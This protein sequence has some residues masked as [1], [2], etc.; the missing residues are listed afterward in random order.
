MS[1]TPTRVDL[2]FAFDRS[3]D[4]AAYCILWARSSASALKTGAFFRTSAGSIE[5]QATSLAV[6]QDRLVDS[7]GAADCDSGV[8]F[9]EPI[10]EM[11]VVAEQYDFAVSLLPPNDDGRSW[12]VDEEFETDAYDRMILAARRRQW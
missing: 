12:A 1:P 3:L 4:V 11:T 9:G 10:R 2:Y 5:I 8:W 7:R 6:Q